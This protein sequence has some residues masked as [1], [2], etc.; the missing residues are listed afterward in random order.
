MTLH[1]K[2]ALIEADTDS[3]EMLVRYS[4]A[5]VEAAR[6]YANPD[7]EAAA[8]ER[9]RNGR[10]KCYEGPHD[11]GCYCWITTKKAVNAALGVTEDDR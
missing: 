6:K 10:P 11:I 1:H 9:H 4:D 2:L 5:I 7:Y 3:W 8:M